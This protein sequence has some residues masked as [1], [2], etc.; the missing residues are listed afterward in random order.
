MVQKFKCSIVIEVKRFRQ[1]VRS[2][3]RSCRG[4]QCGRN[5]D[6]DVS[7]CIISVFDTKWG[8]I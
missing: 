1:R 6:A 5:D 2:G 7:K 3:L 4:S 8:I